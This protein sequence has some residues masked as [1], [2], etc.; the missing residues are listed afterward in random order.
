MPAQLCLSAELKLPTCTALLLDW[1]VQHSRYILQVRAP[2][3]AA[4]GQQTIPVIPIICDVIGLQNT[5]ET[6][7]HKRT[8]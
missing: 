2:H 4:C 6:P 7:V 5:N 1:H 8:L 3:A